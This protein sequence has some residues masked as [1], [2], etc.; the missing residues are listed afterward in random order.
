MALN[1]KKLNRFQ[2]A[3]EGLKETLECSSLL[4][5]RIWFLLMQMWL[6][7]LYNKE[8]GSAIFLM[9]LVETNSI[10]AFVDTR[11]KSKRVQKLRLSLTD[12]LTAFLNEVVTER[13]ASLASFP[14]FLTDWFE[15]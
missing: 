4:L 6:K 11:C 5:V 3:A 1:N 2:Q 14:L 15:V 8:V 9:V 13:L 10:T 12:F 7:R